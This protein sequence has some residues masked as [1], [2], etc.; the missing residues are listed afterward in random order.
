STWMP[1]SDC[2]AHSACQSSL[3]AT[4]PRRVD[5]GPRHCVWV[6]FLPP[7]RT[8]TTLLPA[9][10]TPDP[11]L[12]SLDRRFA[13]PTLTPSGRTPA[14]CAHKI[15]TWTVATCHRAPNATRQTTRAHAPAG[16]RQLLGLALRD[17]SSP[18]NLSARVPSERNRPIAD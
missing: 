14:T 16:L 10:V 4:T 3:C 17:Q 8:S 2:P 1:Q 13:C 18:E 11:W 6:L 7:A 12:L 5:S 15:A 9:K